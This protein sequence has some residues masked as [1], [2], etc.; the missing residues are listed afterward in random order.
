MIALAS[1]ETIEMEEL[2]TFRAAGTA[3][4]LYLMH[5]GSPGPGKL[6]VTISAGIHG[7]EPA[8]VEAVVRFLEQNASN[9]SLLS[10]AC[11]VV[12]PCDNPSGWEL[13]IR[14]NADGVDLNRQFAVRK[15]PPEVALIMKALEGRCFDLV[16]EMHEDVDSPG[17]YMYELAEDPSER[18]GEAIVQALALSGVPIN[19]APVIEEADAE[20]GIIHPRSI[21]RFRKTHLPKAVY[22]YRICGG[23]VITLEPPASVMPL[24]ERVRIELTGLSIALDMIIKQHIAERLA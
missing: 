18:V 3:Y 12:F 23:H 5:L 15:P 24:E 14:E 21:K 19:F 7:D 16:F 1:I 22:T 8:G 11:F 17:F 10:N 2:G 6:S 20:S 9:E 13:N 4:S